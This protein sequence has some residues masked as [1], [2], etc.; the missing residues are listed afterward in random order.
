MKYICQPRSKPQ[1]NKLEFTSLKPF[2]WTRGV[3]VEMTMENTVSRFLFI[4]IDLYAGLQKWLSVLLRAY[5]CIHLEVLSHFDQ[6]NPFCKTAWKNTSCMVVR[7]L[8]KQQI[9][10][11]IHPYMVLWNSLRCSEPQFPN[12]EAGILKKYLPWWNLI[13]TFPWW[14]EVALELATTS[15]EQSMEGGK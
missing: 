3:V 7:Y 2:L 8:D 1:N 9:S 13:T 6:T 5:I 14:V 4:L 11:F 15:K 12:L 10:L